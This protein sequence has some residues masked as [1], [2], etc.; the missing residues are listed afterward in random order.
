MQMT[1][2]SIFFREESS[3]KYIL[4]ELGRF[5]SIAGPVLNKDKNNFEMGGPYSA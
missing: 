4:E 3:V 5:G 1:V 2:T